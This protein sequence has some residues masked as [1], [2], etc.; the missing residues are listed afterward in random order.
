MSS[1]W[2][3]AGECALTGK[4]A[5]AAMALR[6]GAD[7][8]LE[9]PTPW[10][11]VS[12]EP[13]ARGGVGIL[14]A[15]GV[16][17]H[18]LLRQR[19]RGLRPAPGGGGLPGFRGLPG[20]APALSGCG[21]ALRRLP[22]R[23]SPGPPGGG[24]RRLPGQSQRQPGGG[25]PPGTAAGDGGP[26][27]PRMGVPHD[28]AEGRGGLRLGLGHPGLAAA[29]PERPGGALSPRTWQG[30][31]AS[32]AWIERAV[33]SRLRSMTLEEAQR[34]PD[35]GE[36][37]ARRLLDAARGGGGSGGALP[38]GQDQALRHA[39]VRRLALWA[40]LGLEAGG[41]AGGASL[42][43]GPGPHRAGPG[44]F[45]GDGP[46]QPGPRGGQ[47]R[48]RPAAGARGPGPLPPWRTA[49]PLST[50]CASPGHGPAPLSGPPPR[51]SCPDRPP[52]RESAVPARPLARRGT[53]FFLLKGFRIP[54]RSGRGPPGRRC[55]RRICPPEPR[56]SPRWWRS[57]GC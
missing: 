2:V 21:E 23:R 41:S 45:A 46:A 52:K 25:I 1:H 34:L 20:G 51:S 9:I 29:G 31:I 38:P 43:P 47:A 49:A 13:F 39:R 55:R 42:S 12:A 8:V 4:W 35:S 22:P 5:R 14:T 6:G 33:L 27:R 54:R 11:C 24:G 28:G 36:G 30:D 26:G 32:M 48:P 15:A 40:F 50:A 37:L 57:Y 16:V 7:L 3:Q 17:D 19:V 18:P 44:G 53:A 10:A 56:P